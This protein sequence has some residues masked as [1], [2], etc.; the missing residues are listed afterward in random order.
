MEGGSEVRGLRSIP[1]PRETFSGVSRS[2]LPGPRHGRGEGDGRHSKVHLPDLKVVLPFSF[3]PG[4]RSD[5]GSLYYSEVN[6]EKRRPPYPSI[7]RTT[8]IWER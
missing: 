7:Q 6:G 4:L 2:S 5:N 1:R 8:G 3:F